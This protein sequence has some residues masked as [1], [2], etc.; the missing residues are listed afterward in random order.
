MGPYGFLF[1]PFAVMH[2]GGPFDI[3]IGE[4]LNGDSIYKDRPAWAKDLT[5]SSVVRTMWGNFDTLP[6]AGQTMIPRNLGNS[7]SMVGFNMRLSRAFG[8]GP[9][10]AGEN[11]VAEIEHQGHGG[12]GGRGPEIQP[13]DHDCRAQSLQHREPGYPGGKPQLTAVRDLYLDSRFWPR[14][15]IGQPHDRITGSIRLLMLRSKKEIARVRGS[16]WLRNT[17]RRKLKPSAA[18]AMAAADGPCESKRAQS[19]YGDSINTFICTW[20]Y[21]IVASHDPSLKKLKRARGWNRVPKC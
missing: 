13:D 12:A 14:Q 6:I 9:K 16:S 2:T 4:D 17:S 5:R 8:F 1:N 21:S 20:R 10:L 7:P 3:T 11:G 19:C 15:R 18:P